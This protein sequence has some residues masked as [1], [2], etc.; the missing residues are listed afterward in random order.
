LEAIAAGAALERPHLPAIDRSDRRASPPA[1]VV[2]LLKVL[3]KR[4]CDR[5]HVAAKLV[6]SASDLEA[7]ALDDEADVQALHG[8]RRE[9]FG[10]LALKL[11]R[12]EIA[13]KLSDGAVEIVD[14]VGQ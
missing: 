1:D 11:K 10:E 14:V 6:A 4:Q 13:M 5:F 12:G 9:V 8:W 3:L 2:E 7:I